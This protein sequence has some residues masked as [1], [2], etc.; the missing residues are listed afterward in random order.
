MIFVF[1]HVKL[2]VTDSGGLQEESSAFAVPV[3]VLRDFTERAEAIHEGVSILVSDRSSE[4][5]TVLSNLIQDENGMY[6]KMSQQKFPFGDGKTSERIVD[7]LKKFSPKSKCPWRRDVSRASS[8]TTRWT[9]QRRYDVIQ[10]ASIIDPD[11]TIILPIHDGERFLRESL[12]SM[13]D[14]ETSFQVEYV[15]V[16]DFSNDESLSIVLEMAK[17]NAQ[18][19]IVKHTKNL[20]LPESL[21]TG[22]SL[23]RGRWI[24]WT[25]D[26]NNLSVDFAELMLLKAAQFPDAG[27]IGG[28]ISIINDSGEQEVA[29]YLPTTAVGFIDWL[30]IGKDWRYFSIL[31]GSRKWW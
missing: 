22:L 26:D 15:V 28:P 23:S 10:T 3:I 12:Q 1:R 2:V 6:R 8:M 31:Q 7:A 18:F 13:L 11:L 27:I 4:F 20:N 16:D 5:F 17:G 14:Q 25:S 9:E 21:N 19:T 24:S 30:Q 29:P